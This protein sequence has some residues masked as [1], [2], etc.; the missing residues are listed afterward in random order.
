MTCAKIVVLAKIMVSRCASV[1]SKS[2]N[3]IWPPVRIILTTKKISAKT[4]PAREI[5]L[6]ATNYVLPAV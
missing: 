1:Q 6:V 5:P 4:V 2:H 3:K